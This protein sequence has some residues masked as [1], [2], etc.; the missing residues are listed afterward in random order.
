MKAPKLRVVDR[1]PAAV[2]GGDGLGTHLSSPGWVGD[3]TAPGAG[4][5]D[6]R[7]R[8]GAVERIIS[9][10]RRERPS[11]TSERHARP[12][13]SGRGRAGRAALRRGV[14]SRQII[15]RP[16]TVSQGA[17]SQGRSRGVG[18]TGEVE[19]GGQHAEE[20]AGGGGDADEMRACR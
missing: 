3:G 2:G 18:E 6:E 19:V 15:S 8:V 1:R 10:Q 16:T 11:P 13:A 5:V 14:R 7:R 17:T 9:S 4:G 12:A 20:R